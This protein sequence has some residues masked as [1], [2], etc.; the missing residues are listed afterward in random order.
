M[1]REESI[2]TLIEK[3]DNKQFQRAYNGLLDEYTEKGGQISKNECL[4]YLR[5]FNL[6][7][8]DAKYILAILEI[9]N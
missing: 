7:G 5:R 8:K 9:E 6:R 3:F 2:V 1:S 4:G